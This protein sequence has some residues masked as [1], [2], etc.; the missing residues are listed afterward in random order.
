MQSVGEP[1]EA[2]GEKNRERSSHTV[3]WFVLYIQLSAQILYDLQ[4]ESLQVV[5]FGLEKADGMVGALAEMV[6]HPGVSATFKAS[7]DQRIIEKSLIDHLRAAK[8]KQ[9]ATGLY[10][11]HGAGIESLI[12]LHSV[13]SLIEAFGKSRRINDNNIVGIGLL[14][15]EVECILGNDIVSFCAETIESSIFFCQRGSLGRGIE[16]VDP[17]STGFESIHTEAPRIAESVEDRPAGSIASEQLPVF[18]L[19]EEESC[20]LP[21]FPVYFKQVAIFGDGQGMRL[22]PQITIG[23]LLSVAGRQCFAAFIVNSLQGRAILSKK[24]LEG[25]SERMALEV[26]TNAVTLND[27]RMVVYIYD[28]SWQ[29]ITFAMHQPPGIGIRCTSQRQ[30]PAQ[31]QGSCQFLKPYIFRWRLRAKVK[32]T[33]ADTAC[34][35]VAGS[36]Q[37]PAGIDD[38][39]A[40]TV[41]QRTVFMGKCP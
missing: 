17:G 41:S 40:L 9:Q 2:N 35:V 7:G 29:A 21:S 31:L 6:Q 32:N 18:A 38:T 19:V 23:R 12:P 30:R 22:T 26:H 5:A 13:V 3:Y 34:L 8:R 14:A 16:T 37:L 1:R 33:H 15:E 4:H 28:E 10:A 36:E 25:H 27:S 39:Y 11:L 20:L 24:L